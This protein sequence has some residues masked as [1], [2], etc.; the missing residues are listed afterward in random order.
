MKYFFEANKS[1]EKWRE[2][3]LI[4]TQVLVNLGIDYN[5]V[6]G[7]KKWRVEF[8]TTPKKEKLAIEMIMNPSKYQSC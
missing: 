3:L 1:W 2:H 4:Y 7:G 8:K 5:V 6:R